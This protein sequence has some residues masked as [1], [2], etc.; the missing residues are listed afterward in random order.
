MGDFLKSYPSS[1]RNIKDYEFAIQKDIFHNF[2]RDAKNE[3]DVL[4]FE[5][6]PFDY[7]DA[8]GQII[9]KNLK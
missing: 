9:L 4:Y 2:L 5:N 3:K 7:S 1:V 6:I 8:L